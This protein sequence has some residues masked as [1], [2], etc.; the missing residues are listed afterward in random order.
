[1]HRL[2]H[3]LGSRS[4][5]RTVRLEWI[6]FGLLIVAAVA[7]T[8]SPASGEVIRIVV[9]PSFEDVEGGGSVSPATGPIR[10][11]YLI[12]ASDFA[13][14]PDT[15][16]LIV[17]W[18][19][20]SDITQSEPLNWTL[21][22]EQIWM[23]T[24][25]LSNLT[26]VFADNHGPNK[27]LVHD[28]TMIYPLLTTGPPQGPRDFAEGTRLHTPFFYDPSE[29]NLLIE[30]LT[31]DVAGPAQSAV[32]NVVGD[33]QRTQKRIEEQC[34]DPRYLEQIHKCIASRRALLGLD[35]PTKISPT[36]PDGEEA[37][38]SHVMSELMKLAEAQKERPDVIDGAVLDQ[39]L[40]Q[41]GAADDGRECQ[42]GSST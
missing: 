31:F 37:Y 30:R 18:N 9:P 1:M 41:Q 3:E 16:R 6:T 2:G 32:I 33:S 39:M 11:Q 25:N 12:P 22:D 21:D 26:N 14:L 4:C 23:S 28:G 13:E 10:I 20:R 24:T 40:L 34:G 19:F 15:H 42:A 8:V 29:G 38:H 5:P 36:S 17:A 27:S 7:A 35:A